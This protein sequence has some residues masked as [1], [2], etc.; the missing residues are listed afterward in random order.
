MRPLLLPLVLGISLLGPA[1]A[2]DEHAP[3]KAKATKDEHAKPAKEET[4]KAAKEETAKPVK[5]AHGKAM[6]E[7]RKAEEPEPAPKVEKPAAPPRPDPEIARAARRL[8]D[9]ETRLKRIETENSKLRTE[10]AEKVEAPPVVPPGA[11]AVSP[12]GALAELRAGNSRFMTGA[13]TRSQMA[14]NDPALRQT[15][16]KGQSPFAVI[17]TCSDSRLGDNFIF[18]QELGRLF[19]I[20]EA[21]NCPDTQGLASIEYAVEH[22][23]SKVVVVMG[24]GSCGA[25]KAVMESGPKQLPGN[26]WSLQSAMAGL[27]QS[28]RHDPNENPSEHLG[29]LVEAN[30][31]RQAQVVLERS[32]IVRH[33]VETGKLKVVPAVY[34]LSSGKV[35]FLKLP[36]AEAKA[37]AHH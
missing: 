28:V 12:E 3:A 29:H 1:W 25:V 19:T 9:L 30:A 21:G 33:L 27:L 31:L 36:E 13:R 15:L 14:A 32:E 5:D 16:A 22:L 7:T 23:G 34:D 37:P 35:S 8:R 11:E 20:R 2:S 26:L 18:D 24:H 10:L 4:A 6:K 17:V